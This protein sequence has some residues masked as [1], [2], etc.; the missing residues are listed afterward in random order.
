MWEHYRKTFVPTQIAIVIICVV[1]NLRFGV[2][3]PALA[4]FVVV[5]ELF[6]VIG[7]LWATRL[8]RKVDNA[9]RAAR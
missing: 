6:A 2:A 7:A 8:T 9:R 5:M 1:L 4:V 3:I